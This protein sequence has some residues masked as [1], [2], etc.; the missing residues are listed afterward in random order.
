M[1][2]YDVESERFDTTYKRMGYLPPAPLPREELVRNKRL[3]YFHAG[4]Y[5]QGARDKTAAIAWD[6]YANRWGA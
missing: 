3:Q 5:A 2:E 1:K 6:I 4:R